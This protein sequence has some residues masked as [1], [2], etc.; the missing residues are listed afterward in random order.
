MLLGRQLG[1][2]WEEQTM[3]LHLGG[4]LAEVPAVAVLVR[5]EVSGLPPAALVMAWVKET[6]YKIRP[7]LGQLNFFRQYKITFEGYHETFDISVKP[8]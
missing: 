7:V 8:A 4:M 2:V 1:L 5:G 6:R 3:P